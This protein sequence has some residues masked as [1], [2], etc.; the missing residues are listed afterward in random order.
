MVVNALCAYNRPYFF[1]ELKKKKGNRFIK[2]YYE[3]RE[4]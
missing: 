1:S 4:T 3:M 2:N